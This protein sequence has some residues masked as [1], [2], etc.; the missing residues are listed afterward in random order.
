M[1]GSHGRW[2][3]IATAESWDGGT[4]GTCN[5]FLYRFHGVSI[6]RTPGGGWTKLVGGYTISSSTTRLARTSRKGSFLAAEG[7]VALRSLAS[8]SP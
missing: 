3:P 7:D 4:G 8:F 2:A 1:P 6:A 5:G